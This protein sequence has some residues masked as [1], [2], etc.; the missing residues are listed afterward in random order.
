MADKITMDKNS[1]TFQ[2]YKFITEK[3]AVITKEIY[4][5]F[6]DRGIRNSHVSSY[7]RQLLKNNLIIKSKRRAQSKAR[8][9][10]SVFVYGITQDD[11]NQKI[12]RLNSRTDEKEFLQGVKKEIF[13]AL[14]DSEDGYTTAEVLY[15]LREK[16]YYKDY[17]NYDHVYACLNDLL[18]LQLIKRSPFMMPGNAMIHGRKPGYVYGKDEKAIYNKILKLMPKEVRSAY[19]LISQSNEI[20]NIDMTKDRFKVTYNQIKS[21]FDYRFISLGWIKVVIYKQRRYYFNRTMPESFVLQQAP[22]LH[23]KEVVKS[24]LD[25]TTLGNGFEEQAIF[26]F[27]MYLMTRYNLQIRLNKDFPKKIPSWFN[28]KDIKRYTDEKE[29]RV[30]DV[31]KFDSEPIDYL[32]FCYDQ[33]LK[34]PIFGFAVSIKR[35]KK[36]KYLGS[37]GKKYITSMVGCLSH[38]RSLDM[39]PI[40]MSHKLTPVLIMNN[41]NGIKLFEWAKHSGVLLLWMKKVDLLRSFCNRVGIRYEKDLELD[42]LRRFSELFDKYKDHEDVVLGKS[43]IRRLIV[44][45]GEMEL[46]VI[47]DEIEKSSTV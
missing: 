30:C 38:R 19:L 6:K 37:A 46:E 28:P 23:K 44:E 29:K 47:S 5:A 2:I 33:L 7:L 21:W 41:P 12:Q 45:I 3:R 32:V 1:T 10:S 31:W 25:V 15:L 20:Y 8:K 34:V 22:K 17:G 35:D 36:G 43:S 42:R 9:C 16:E 40:P 18:K 14:M 39:R 24:I 26:Y 27:V 13:D 4:D 11:I